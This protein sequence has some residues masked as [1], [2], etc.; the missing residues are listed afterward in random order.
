MTN[1]HAG[2]ARA[3]GSVHQVGSRRAGHTVA[4]IA[5][6]GLTGDLL[7]RAQTVT[8]PTVSA[9]HVTVFD[10]ASRTSRRV[11]TGAGIWEA[12]NWSRDGRTLLVNSGGRL[13]TLP[14]D[15]S[16]AP[17]GLALDQSYR[18]NNDHDWSPDG[19][20]LAFSASSPSSPQ[21]QVYVADAAGRNPRLLVPAPLSY[22]H[23]WSPDGRYVSFVGRRD[24]TQFDLYRISVEGG[25]EER[26]TT[27][28]AHDDGTDYSRDGS[29][30]YF[31]SERAGG[32]DIWRMPSDG[33][34]ANDALAQRITTD[35][36]EDWF[37]HPSPDGKWLVFVSF[38]PGTKGHS[39]RTLQ[40]QLRRIPL[41]GRDVTPTAPE[42][43]ATVTGGQG[44]MNVNSWS[45]DGTAFA[46]VTFEPAR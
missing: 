45:P 28:L 9:S 25:T 34:G 35:Q 39:D 18:C 16:S 23:G 46:Y 21:S 22:F 1:Q 41:P 17:T 30:I 32:N 38:P 2:W 6:A 15:G 11:Y 40:V 4:L 37:P 20:H 36:W 27:N 31:N 12:P 26:L 14:V 19:K 13:Y 24:G 44:T 42:V 33:A 43:L 7:V 3:R 29:W 8:A 10:L 5:A